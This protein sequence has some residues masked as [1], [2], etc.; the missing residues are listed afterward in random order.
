MR[1][2]PLLC[3]AL[4]GCELN[5]AFV[6]SQMARSSDA[7]VAGMWHANRKSPYQS[8][9][10][11]AEEE[12]QRRGAIRPQYRN[13]IMAEEVVIGMTKAEAAAAWGSPMRVNKTTTARG[14][15]DQ[16]VFAGRRNYLYF[17]KGVLTAIQ[18]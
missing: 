3:L 8:A 10:K 9:A 11:Q 6:H 17:D 12:L 14:E 5:P 2:L 18:N 1:F 13:K 7:E 15:W 16:W 4:V